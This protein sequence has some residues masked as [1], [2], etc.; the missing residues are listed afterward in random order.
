MFQTQRCWEC[1]DLATHGSQ[2]DG[3]TCDR[4]HQ[5]QQTHA[6]TPSVTVTVD[7]ALQAYAAQ[8][9]RQLAD[10]DWLLDIGVEPFEIDTSFGTV[11]EAMVHGYTNITIQ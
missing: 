9:E 5:A 4:H 1:G 10:Q 8:V 7:E 3:Y 11:V 2:L 6:P